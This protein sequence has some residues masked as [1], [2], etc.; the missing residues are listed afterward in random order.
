[1]ETG[2]YLRDKYRNVCTVLRRT[3]RLK[4]LMMCCTGGAHEGKFFLTGQAEFTGRVS[5]PPA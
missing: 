3:S 4:V 5:D 2:F 1:M